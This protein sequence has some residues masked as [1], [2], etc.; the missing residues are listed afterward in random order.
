MDRECKLANIVV[1]H[2]AAVIER[3]QQFYSFHER[4]P[5]ALGWKRRELEDDG[6]LRFRDPVAA[7]KDDLT[8]TTVCVH[9]DELGASEGRVRLHKRVKPHD[10]ERLTARAPPARPEPLFNPQMHLAIVLADN[11]LM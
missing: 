1:E 8:I 9:L 10:A 3:E 2:Q 5:V 4:P 11:P 6:R 7:S